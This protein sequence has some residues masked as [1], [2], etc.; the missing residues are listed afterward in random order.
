MSI[1]AIRVRLSYFRESPLARNPSNLFW[2]RLRREIFQ[3]NSN[4]SNLHFICLICSDLLDFCSKSTRFVSI[5]VISARRALLLFLQ[6]FAAR[7]L[8]R[9]A[10]T[11]SVGVALTAVV[12][13]AFGAVEVPRIISIVLRRRPVVGVPRQAQITKTYCINHLLPL[14]A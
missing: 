14:I 6:S 12:P 5:C 7:G 9:Q 13:N 4:L 8:E 10:G 2:G 1:R 3:I 11:N